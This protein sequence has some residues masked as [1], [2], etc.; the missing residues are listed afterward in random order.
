MHRRHATPD[1]SS[2]PQPIC[3]HSATPQ[4]LP[5]L[6]HLPRVAHIHHSLPPVHQKANT[7][8]AGTETT[9]MATPEEQTDVK[10]EGMLPKTPGTLRPPTAARTP[11]KLSHHPSH[12]ESHAWTRDR[13]TSRSDPPKPRTP[14]PGLQQHC[15]TLLPAR[16]LPLA[17]TQQ[18]H[19]APVL[20][21]AQPVPSNTASDPETGR[22]GSQAPR[23]RSTARGAPSTGSRVHSPTTSKFSDERSPD[24]RSS[25]N[26]EADSE[27][28]SIRIPSN[29][30]RAL[31]PTKHAT[32]S[33]PMP[34]LDHAPTLA[35]LHTTT[36]LDAKHAAILR[37]EGKK[38]AAVLSTI[39]P[40]NS[41]AEVKSYAQSSKSPVTPTP[42][43]CRPSRRPKTAR[44]TYSTICTSST[45]KSSSMPEDRSTELHTLEVTHAAQQLTRRSRRPTHTFTPT[46]RPCRSRRVLAPE[47]SRH[48]RIAQ[49][50]HQTYPRVMPH[51]ASKLARH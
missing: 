47:P 42:S 19:H 36:H 29:T 10:A 1:A 37:P 33:A 30:Q 13:T 45:Q 3:N 24:T 23:D 39:P 4:P 17:P 14:T 9:R 41:N 44:S 27:P 49:L 21:P 16:V 48:T 51:E 46:G 25:T 6:H 20:H 40:A 50:Q 8:T 35:G 7:S 31:P 18:L 28:C 38:A 22:T 5:T 11:S 26:A 2:V 15:P 34:T 32:R 12:A 43:P